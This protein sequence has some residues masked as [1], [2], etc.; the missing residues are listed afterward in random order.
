VQAIDGAF[1]GG[2]FA[3]EQIFI[4]PG[5]GVKPAWCLNVTSNSAVLFDSVLRSGTASGYFEWGLTTD[6]GNQTPIQDL[7][8]NGE[9]T[10]HAALTNL[11]PGSY[12]YFRA[13]LTNG[14]YTSR[15]GIVSFHTDPS[16]ILG[17]T[18]GDGQLDS[19]EAKALLTHYLGGANTILTNVT[20]LGGGNFQMDVQPVLPWPFNLQVSSDL[21]NWSNAVPN[22]TVFFRFFDPQS[23]NSQQRFY[24]FR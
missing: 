9:R 8:G 16:A 4:I 11:T 12:Y 18:D 17:D 3:P 5:L 6:F 7:S 23:T 1:A 13:V 20:S 19:T 10:F 21:V 24:R 2:A 22:G 14:A 15:T